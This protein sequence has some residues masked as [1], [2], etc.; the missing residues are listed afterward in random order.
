MRR[1]QWSSR[2]KFDIILEGLKGEA[3]IGTLCARHKISPA[4]YSRWREQFM[5]HGHCAFDLPRHSR[6]EERLREDNRRLKLLLEKV[7]T[8]L[9]R[10][11]I[12][13]GPPKTPR[14]TKKV[15]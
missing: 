4:Q 14:K 6:E 2:E 7:R 9:E 15:T 10:I 5:Q 8:G 12:E 1:R 13:T 3:E 11:D